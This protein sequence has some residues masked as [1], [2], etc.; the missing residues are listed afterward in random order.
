MLLPMLR[1]GRLHLSGIVVLSPHLTAE[2]RQAL[3]PRA[4]H[5]TKRQIEQLVAALAP[6]PD[7]PAVM[8]KLPFS[9]MARTSSASYAFI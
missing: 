9:R 4:V 2:N 8:R 7:A 6:Q 1:D 5:K 3:L